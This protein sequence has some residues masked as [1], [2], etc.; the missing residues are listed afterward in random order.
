ME[1]QYILSYEYK[2]NIN[3][4]ENHFLDFDYVNASQLLVEL[5]NFATNLTTFHSIVGLLLYLIRILSKID[6]TFN[7]YINKNLLLDPIF[8]PIQSS[9]IKMYKCSVLNN[10]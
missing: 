7:S 1:T 8:T 10:K 2:S 9:I 6:N 5:R 4:G 3:G